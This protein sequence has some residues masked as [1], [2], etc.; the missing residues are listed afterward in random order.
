[1]AGGIAHDFNNL[2]AVVAGNIELAK[3]T[4]S[5]DQDQFR[6]LEAAEKGAFNAIALS[7]QLLTFSKGGAP[8][9]KTASIREL[10][11]DSVDFVLRGSS[12]RPERRIPKDLFPADIDTAQISQVFQNLIIN[13]EQAMPEGG[14]IKIHAENLVNPNPLPPLLT[15]GK[16]DRYIKIAIQDSGIG[17]PAEYLDK[18][19]DPFFTTKKK[20]TGLGLSIVF[21]IIRK[22]GGC[23]S[24]DSEPGKGTKFEIYLPA[25]D[26]QI[27]PASLSAAESTADTAHNRILIMDDSKDIRDLLRLTLRKIGHET[28]EATDGQKAIDAYKTAME[29]GEPFD[30]VI[31]DLTIS[32]GMGGKEAI[33]KLRELHPDV[34]A[35][36]FSGYSND[37]VVAN[38]K[39]YG[40]KGTISKPFKIKQLRQ[41]LHDVIHGKI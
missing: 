4:A 36:V 27:K 6:L 3:L 21:S 5:P 41:V 34:K 30:A 1:L 26:K 23:I 33:I 15:P 24:A 29:K 17:I 9:K 32:G 39:D 18:I 31:M 37:P 28:S 7:Q 12:V 8:I 11:I 35:I 16:H 10:I 20:G 19:F 13:A 14:V 40:F 38:Y 22:H 25:S 2:L